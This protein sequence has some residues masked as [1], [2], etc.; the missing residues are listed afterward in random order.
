LFVSERYRQLHALRSAAERT[1]STLKEDYS[2]LRKP[3]VRSLP[4]AAAVSQMGVIT[5]LMD[6]VTRFVLD[7][8]IK[9]RKFKATGDKTW[10]DRLSPPEIP[11]YLKP[12]VKTG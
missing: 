10:F 11:S 5:M 7:N 2:I 1:N 9:E 3:P 8:T 4:R 6:R 12:F